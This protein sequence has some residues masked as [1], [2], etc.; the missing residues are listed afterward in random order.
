MSHVKDGLE[1]WLDWSPSSSAG[2][3]GVGCLVDVC[4]DSHVR[5]RLSNLETTQRN[6]GWIYS[7]CTT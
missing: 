4:G 1:P 6:D 5:S 7:N 2:L 3:L